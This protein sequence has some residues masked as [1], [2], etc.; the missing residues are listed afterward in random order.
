LPGSYDP[1]TILGSFLIAC[2]AGYVAFESIDHTQFSE[3]PRRWA[4]LGGC[5]LGL[6]IWSM[7]FVG[8]MAWKPD[9]PLYYSVGRTLLSVLIA[10]AA[11]IYAMLRV[12]RNQFTGK[13]NSAIKK[14]VIVGCGI[15]AMHYVGMSALKFDNGVMW[16]PFWVVLSL[17]IAIGGSWAAMYLFERSRTDLASF[18]RRILASIAIGLAIC[19][20]HYA[21]MEAFMPN[22]SSICIH[23]PLSF[24]GLI[25]ARIGVGNALLFT[26]V[27]L[28]ASHREKSVWIHMVSDTRLEAVTTARRLENSMLVQKIAVSV[29]R[30]I[31]PAIQAAE[32]HFHAIRADE[33]SASGREHCAAVQ[34]ELDRI[35]DAV[36]YTSQFFQPQLG[37]VE[38][39]IPKLF[40]SV[41]ALFQSPLRAS[42]IQLQASVPDNLPTILC[43]QNEVRHV[44]ASLVNNAIE[45]MP[46]GG[47]LRL[48]ARAEKDGL[49][50]TV[51][52]TGR[53]VPSILHDRIIKPF[54]TTKG[55]KGRGLTLAIVTETI[56]H[57]GG[58]SNFESPAP[59]S[60]VG[61]D[62]HFFLPFIPNKS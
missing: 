62:F 11:S 45:V 25:L 18:N 2:F 59:G 44:L 20:M 34:H 39:S 23:Q 7:H 46:E 27:L 33:L 56:R 22:P 51:A 53:V 8:M 35:A 3:K 40:E 58:T 12:V 4:V 30:E 29:V 6:G 54:V 13:S 15:C 24:S 14:A 32:N 5:A 50:L 52:D 36:S 31:D 38:T 19:G 48:A 21:G 26:I 43:R 61:T 49:T 10:I 55:L 9:Y 47:T 37:L 42:N 16:K 60:E 41:I 17:G 57:I 1:W 28:L